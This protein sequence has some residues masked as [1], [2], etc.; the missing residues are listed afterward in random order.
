MVGHIAV[1]QFDLVRMP[2]VV[3][4]KE[5]DELLCGNLPACISRGCGAA[6]V[7]QGGDDA[8]A[9]ARMCRGERVEICKRS[10][11]AAVIDK[12]DLGRE[13]RL[14]EHLLQRPRDRG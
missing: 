10:V 6:V 12:S 13:K 3:S 14:S 7:T 9:L 4:V 1:L 2:G 11:T 5:C 8:N